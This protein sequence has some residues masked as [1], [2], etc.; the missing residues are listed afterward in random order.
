M[1]LNCNE[2][3]IA[4]TGRDEMREPSPSSPSRQP[5]LLGVLANSSRSVLI[6][7][8]RTAVMVLIKKIL[9]DFCLRKTAVSSPAKTYSDI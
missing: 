7:L 1:H 3:F 5:K 6:G 8:Q 2:K 9:R 4:L